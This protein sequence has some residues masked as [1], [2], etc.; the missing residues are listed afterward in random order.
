MTRKAQRPVRDVRCGFSSAQ[1]PLHPRC[2]YIGPATRT[3]LIA[4]SRQ[5]SLAHLQRGQAAL[6]AGTTRHSET[7]TL[8]APGC[9]V[10]RRKDA[11]APPPPTTHNRYLRLVV[12]LGKAPTTRSKSRDPGGWRTCGGAL[13]VG[14]PERLVISDRLTFLSLEQA[15]RG[16]GLDFDWDGDAWRTN[17]PSIGRLQLDMSSVSFMQLRALLALVI[18]VGCSVEAGAEVDVLIPSREEAR[19]FLRASRFL[20]ALRAFP[21]KRLHVSVGGV[22]NDVADETGGRYLRMFPLTWATGSSLPDEFLTS[23]LSREIGE[24]LG[25]LPLD[26]ARAI[27]SLVTQEL[28]EN[29]AVHA[30]APAALVAAMT[31]LSPYGYDIEDL[32]PTEQAFRRRDRHWHG[33][34]QLCVADAGA[35]IANTLQA[36][37]DGL[38][39]AELMDLAFDRWT[40]SQEASWRRGTRGLY[41]IERIAKRSEGFVTARSGRHAAT[42]VTSH[43]G[44]GTTHQFGTTF[45]GSLVHVE[46]PIDAMDRSSSAVVLSHVVVGSPPPVR[47]AVMGGATNDDLFRELT[48]VSAPGE[49]LVFDFS[50]LRCGRHEAVDLV[51][52]LSELA[53]PRACC[54]MGL[55]FDDVA[56]QEIALDVN[57]E[58]ARDFSG[59]TLAEVHEPVLLVG[60][61]FHSTYWAGTH[62]EIADSL[63]TLE[64]DQEF[65]RSAKG[66]SLLVRSADGTWKPRLDPERL[67]SAAEQ[68][69]GEQLEPWSR[70]PSKGHLVTASLTAVSEYVNVVGFLAQKS[71]R[72]THGLLARLLLTEMLLSEPALEGQPVSLVV[73]GA[74]SRS[75][76]DALTHA[77]DPTARRGRVV[78]RLA[79]RDIETGRPL[80]LDTQTEVACL[81]SG[82]GT[83]QT[84][85]Q[86][87]GA[88]LR[89]GYRLRGALTLLDTRADIGA[90]IE[91]WGR[92]YWL[93]SVLDSPL[94]MT[95][96]LGR[97]RYLDAVG[98]LEKRSAPET[99]PDFSDS[100][101][102]LSET[103]GLVLGHFRGAHDNHFTF[104]LS[105]ESVLASENASQRLMQ[106][107][108][109]V[110][111]TWHVSLQ[112]GT[113]IRLSSSAG[114]DNPGG[115]LFRKALVKAYNA[116][117]GATGKLKFESRQ[118]LRVPLA[119]LSVDWGAVS[120]R[121]ILNALTNGSAAGA[122][123]VLVL[124]GFS[125]M[126]PDMERHVLSI[127][128]LRTNVDTDVNV[129]FSFSLPIDAY[130]P[131]TC[132]LC[133]MADRH[134]RA[135][136]SRL[137]TEARRENERI[138][139]RDLPDVRDEGPTLDTAENA[140]NLGAAAALT[141]R[142]ELQVAGRSTARA[143]ACQRELE[144]RLSQTSY[145]M[146]LCT[147]IM[148]EPQW[149]RRPPLSH[150]HT[151]ALLAQGIVDFLLPV[152]TQYREPADVENAIIALRLVSK[153][154]FA[155]NLDALLT[156]GPVTGSFNLVCHLVHGILGRP[157]VRHTGIPDRIEAGL[158][159]ARGKLVVSEVHAEQVEVLDDLLEDVRRIGFS[160]ELESLPYHLALLRFGDS[161]TIFSKHD[162]RD[163][164]DD[165]LRH[166]EAGRYDSA[167]VAWE[168]VN[169]W[170]RSRVQPAVDLFYQVLRNT[171]E[172][173]DH[174][175]VFDSIFGD[176]GSLGRADIAADLVR[177][178]ARGVAPLSAAEQ[179]SIRQT[180]HNIRE[181]VV[182]A[183]AG[184]NR[185][186]RLGRAVAGCAFTVH[187]MSGHFLDYCRSHRVTLFVHPTE[188]WNDSLVLP[189]RFLRTLIERVADN[190]KRLANGPPTLNLYY[191]RVEDAFNTPRYGF[192]LLLV[193]MDTR[194]EDRDPSK[195]GPG[196]IAELDATLT[197]VR[198]TGERI[199][200]D[201]RHDFVTKV[202]TERDTP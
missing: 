136:N 99:G 16:A 164:L 88:T 129:A 57:D 29:V 160:R 59:E 112:P 14:S 60:S 143:A 63:R 123:S 93:S 26:T 98:D 71:S 83:G 92:E 101:A 66:L 49:L 131:E 168:H 184:D 18:V 107:L 33:S 13:S 127:R 56:L 46:L 200:R 24:G 44:Q 97:Q 189:D 82:V 81:V 125:I 10:S 201:G 178:A 38:S 128:A 106:P 202:T 118:H 45:P 113:R 52:R 162:F 120:G 87:M 116:S 12:G 50:T 183:P 138:A 195:E 7:L 108:L 126:D 104:G 139:I 190:V 115:Q 69:F 43:D 61:S 89:Q 134:T 30:K 156:E 94:E 141:R 150:P 161:L 19:G 68:A 198:V 181:L 153:L 196:G 157:Y 72:E 74:V 174:Q 182:S 140:T 173:V 188:D 179:S 22:S 34:V 155:D 78:E 54:V 3:C 37:Y 76:C 185:D 48:Q 100:I 15:R 117:Q 119:V 103:A 132:P 146:S 135:I 55:P 192:S 170:L 53:H 102:V 9:G 148:F 193:S 17:H 91:L 109:R 197:H 65:V 80:S 114:E 36:S 199:T 5:Q 152:Q 41:R 90:P 2:R 96:P 191:E 147:L 28:L 186:S 187:Q 23:V 194:K 31:S 163:P 4:S 84:L 176:Q 154:H 180:A 77:M 8:T 122:H 133:V 158:I 79:L 171:H 95:V 11:R 86:L 25:S 51:R 165:C 105:L 62:P 35:G 40:T 144:K 64:I 70:K 47:V 111:R 145:L 142:A 85:R 175:E 166:M 73:E 169:S 151:R 167:A 67:W 149:L 32:L 137:R 121:S 124:R 177:R 172:L 42:R 130:T 21:A 159:R 27:C 110:L 1:G 6:T 75:L 58:L 39:S 20:E